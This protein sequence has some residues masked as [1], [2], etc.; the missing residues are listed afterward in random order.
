MAHRF[1]ACSRASIS[2]RSA[3]A[4]TEMVAIIRADQAPHSASNC[5]HR[6]QDQRHPVVNFGHKLIGVGGDDSERADP[7]ARIRIP[8]VLPQSANAERLAI[9]HGDRVGLL[10]LLALDRLPFIEAV[11]RE[12]AAAPAIRLPKHWQPVRRLA[13]GVDRL[14]PAVRVLA[15]GGNKAPAQRVER[16]LAGLV[17][18]P[19][20]QELLAWCSIP[21]G[22]I[23]VDSVV[24]HVEAFDDAVP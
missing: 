24:T 13:F 10:R 11:H 6:S 1:P 17:I 16:D 15:P 7:L 2:A 12:N 23:V 22:W 14:A 18:A 20:D 21:A 19:N 4:P 3:S 8:P 9:L 5:S